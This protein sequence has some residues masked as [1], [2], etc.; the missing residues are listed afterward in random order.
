MTARP[1]RILLAQAAI[2]VLAATGTPLRA[3]DTLRPPLDQGV[4]VGISYTP[5]LR[6]GMLMLGGPRRELF[7]SVRAIIAR[8]IKKWT[9]VAKAANIKAD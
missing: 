2:G 7:D 6:P 9:A 5:G 3:Q 8:D 1:L 4:R